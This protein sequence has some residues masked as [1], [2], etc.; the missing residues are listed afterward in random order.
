MTTAQSLKIYLSFT[1]TVRKLQ[2]ITPTQ[3]RPW[4]L[5]DPSLVFDFGD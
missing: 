1:V 5:V 3:E 2:D 4:Y